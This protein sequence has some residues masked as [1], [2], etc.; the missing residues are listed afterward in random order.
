MM[1]FA[2]DSDNEVELAGGSDDEPPERQPSALG[3]VAIL[4]F[5]VAGVVVLE[6]RCFSVSCF[7]SFLL[8][9]L[10]LLVFC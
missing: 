8:S 1:E 7:P 3:G 2:G 6:S 4:C 9:S 5:I 10:L